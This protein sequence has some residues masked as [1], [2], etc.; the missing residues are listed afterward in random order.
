MGFVIGSVVLNGPAAI[1]ADDNSVELIDESGA[2]VGTWE[3]P[4]RELAT[5]LIEWIDRGWPVADRG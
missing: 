2:V 4:K 3:G 5:R 1:G